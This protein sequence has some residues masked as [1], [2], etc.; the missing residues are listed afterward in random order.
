MC[1]CPQDVGDSDNQKNFDL[2]SCQVRTELNGNRHR[3]Q[4]ISEL[5]DQGLVSS[6]HQSRRK[7]KKQR[8][9]DNVSED[10]NLQLH[11]IIIDTITGER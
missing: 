2:S 6:S 11:E 5:F 3:Q 1:S 4:N 8:V 10:W 9:E 7:K